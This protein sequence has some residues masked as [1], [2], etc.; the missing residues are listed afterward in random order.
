[1]CAYYVYYEDTHIH[2]HTHTHTRTHTHEHNMY[3]AHKNAI[4]IQHN[5]CAT[6]GDIHIHTCTHSMHT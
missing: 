4:H 1:M 3:A 2:T 6:H 5:T